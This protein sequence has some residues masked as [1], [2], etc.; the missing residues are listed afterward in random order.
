MEGLRPQDLRRVTDFLE[1]LYAFADVA[2]LRGRLLTSLPSLIRADRVS[3]IESNPR[4]KQASGESAPAGAFDGDLARAYGT[5]LP[6]SPMLRAYKRGGGSAVKYSDFL[7]QRQLH[8]LGLYNEYLRKL[9]AEYRIAKG[10]PGRQGWITTVQ[11]DRKLQDFSE[12]D[13]LVL[14]VLR[15]H[16]NQSYRNAVAVTASR[17]R[18]AEIEHGLDTLERGLV[19]LGADGSVPW[20]SSRARQWLEGYFP[21]PRRGAILPNPVIDWLRRHT[22][23]RTG[24]MPEPRWPLVVEGQSAQLVIRLVSHGA[25]SVLLL[26]EQYRAMPREP[27]RS[28]GLTQRETEVLA[29][30]TEGKTSDEIASILR[31]ARRTVE[32]HLEHIYQKLGVETRTAAAAR[33]FSLLSPRPRLGVG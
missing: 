5:F 21:G 2:E 3:L 13:R 14:N 19:L 18:L 4:L 15:P 30:V 23:V 10:L 11:L 31:T 33:A 1:E 16:L 22:S 32:K 29:W 8:R 24:E 12:R 26:E 6:Q 9:D 27:L 20:L 28:L 17:V 25:R 7:T